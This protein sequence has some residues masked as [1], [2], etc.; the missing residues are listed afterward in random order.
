M[1]LV[2]IEMNSIKRLE[3]PGPAGVWLIALLCLFL[4]VPAA[5]LASPAEDGPARQSEFISHDL[6]TG[7]LDSPAEAG[8]GS[9]PSAPCPETQAVVSSFVPPDRMTSC[10]AE[11]LP[12][13]TTSAWLVRCHPLFLPRPPPFS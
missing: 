11:F 4:I 5:G 12:D 3:I 13:V 1:T 10:G 7:L 9:R 6:G 2:P 8:G